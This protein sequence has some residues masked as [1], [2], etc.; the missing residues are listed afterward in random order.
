MG[1]RLDRRRVGLLPLLA[2]LYPAWW[3][4]RGGDLRLGVVSAGISLAVAGLGAGVLPAVVGRPVHQVHR[5]AATA[6]TLVVAGA[7]VPTI[8]VTGWL[9]SRRPA[10]RPDMQLDTLASRMVMALFVVLVLGLLL[11]AATSPRRGGGWVQR[12]LAR[13][14]GHGSCPSCGMA[15]WRLEVACSWCGAPTGAES[16][17]EHGTP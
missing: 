15:S 1:S 10:V 4:V 6:W 7:L 2:L 16:V 9:P 17:G 8:L 5:R 13:S 12:Q 3:L 14:W 11:G